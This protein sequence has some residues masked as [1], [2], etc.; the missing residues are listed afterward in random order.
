MKL[1]YYSEEKLKEDILKILSKYSEESLFLPLS[2][3]NNNKRRGSF[4]LKS[5]G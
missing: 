3:P 4:E 2:I 1:E 5:S